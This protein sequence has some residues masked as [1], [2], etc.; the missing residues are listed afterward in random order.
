MRFPSLVIDHNKEMAMLDSPQLHVAVDIGCHRHRVALGAGDGR[1]LEEFDITHD[2]MGFRTF[3][4][5]V[6]RHERRLQA[7]VLIAM[8]GFN[9]WA[10]PLDHQIRAHGY[11]L[12]N[13][14][15]PAAGQG[16]A[17]RS[18]AHPSAKRAPQ[19]LDPATPRPG[20]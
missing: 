15:T 10:R 13:V 6:R 20:E 2:Q 18:G 16:G 19:A 14:N 3:F 11:R 7:A 5:Q 1:V 12:Y 8:E 9:G 17:P 4:R